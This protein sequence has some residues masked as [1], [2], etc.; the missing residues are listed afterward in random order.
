[1]LTHFQWDL[2]HFLN[3]KERDMESQRPEDE[4]LMIT[5]RRESLDNIWSQDPRT[6]TVNTT[7][8]KKLGVPEREGL[9]L[10]DW[11][12]PMRPCPLKD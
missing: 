7:M 8:L 9:G 5:I 3:M 4:I 2:C 11:F 12:P 10:E 1:M 6:V